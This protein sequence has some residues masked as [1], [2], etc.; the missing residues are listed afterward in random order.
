MTHMID[1]NRRAAL[2][3]EMNET[4]INQVA[5]VKT[6]IVSQSEIN[7]ALLDHRQFEYFS[8]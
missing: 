3:F 6:Q 2:Q 7:E 5:A 4:I 1:I 8:D